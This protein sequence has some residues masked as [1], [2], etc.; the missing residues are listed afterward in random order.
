MCTSIEKTIVAR[1]GTEM[2]VALLP[3]S[4]H[5]FV[6]GIEQEAE[7]LKEAVVGH[8]LKEWCVRRPVGGI[9]RPPKTRPAQEESSGQC[10]GGASAKLKTGFHKSPSLA[11]RIES[12]VEVLLAYDFERGRP[13]PKKEVARI[14]QRFG[15]LLVR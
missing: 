2:G 8:L 7:D 14:K 9:V 1:I 4:K 12:E 5:L 11:S 3:L 15:C 13:W 6:V 10:S